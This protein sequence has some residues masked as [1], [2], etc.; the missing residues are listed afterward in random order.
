MLIEAALLR[1]PTITSYP[2]EST[3]VERHLIKRGGIMKLRNYTDIGDTI[4][5]G[6]K[7]PKELIGEMKDPVEFIVDN[8]N[9]FKMVFRNPLWS[10]GRRFESAPGY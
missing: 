10:R 7:R 2:G 1:V 6:V 5:R 4:E 8:Y 9:L 3:Y